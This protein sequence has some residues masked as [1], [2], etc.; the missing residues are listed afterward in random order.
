MGSFEQ[1]ADCGSRALE[2]LR[3]FRFDELEYLLAQRERLIAAAGGLEPQQ[4][5]VLAEID[6]CFVEEARR[7]LERLSV[8]LKETAR[9]K[10]L[11]DT[12]RPRLGQGSAFVDRAV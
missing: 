6:A 12:Y 1:L 11:L 9:A 4:V 5:Q 10:S 8:A 3:D 7:L 2:L